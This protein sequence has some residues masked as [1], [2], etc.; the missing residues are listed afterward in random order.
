MKK[1]TSLLMIALFELIILC[2][3]LTL[4]IAFSA[5]ATAAKGSAEKGKGAWEVEWNRAVEAAKKEGKVLVYSTPSGDIIRALAGPFEKKYGIK[6]EWI[7][8]RGEELTQRMQT[9]KT[10]G[11]KAV[12]VVIS[13]GT[14]TKTVMKPLGLLGRL[15]SELILPEVNKPEVWGGWD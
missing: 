4:S 12:D 7:N 3:P 9:E 8:G 10:A 14:S 13:G 11:I 15:D 5:P 1:L 6:V 2:Q